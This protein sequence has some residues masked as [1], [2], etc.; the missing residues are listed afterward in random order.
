M[1]MMKFLGLAAVAI[2][3]VAFAGQPTLAQGKPGKAAKAAKTHEGHLGKQLAELNLTDAQK[4]QIKPILMDHHKAV[5]AIREDSKLTADEKKTKVK[6]LGKDAHEK[7]LAIL[8]PEQKDKLKALHHK[9]KDAKGGVP[10]PTTAP[11][12]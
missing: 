9:G 1:K 7:I 10:A 11:K 3:I 6:D 4:S 2:S 5:Q 8:T 12:P